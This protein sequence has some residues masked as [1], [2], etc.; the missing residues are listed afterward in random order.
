M[1]FE[2]SIGFLTAGTAEI[3]GKR[4]RGTRPGLGIE[5]RA[6]VSQSTHYVFIAGKKRTPLRLLHRRHCEIQSDYAEKTVH[7][8]QG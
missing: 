1:M 6:A 8:N 2:R 7:F 4:M 3:V 5:R